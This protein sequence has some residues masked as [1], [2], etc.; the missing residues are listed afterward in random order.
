MNMFNMAQGPAV[1]IM[2]HWSQEGSDMD[3]EWLDATLESIK[4]QT[5]PNWKIL[6][7]DGSSPSKKAK[8]YLKK[9]EDEFGGKLEVIFME[10]S[11]GPGHARNVAIKKAYESGYPFL[12]FLDAD[13]IA[14]SQRVEIARKMF[15]EKPETGVVYS[16]F[17]V[18]DEYGNLVPQDKLS[19][20]IVEILESHEHNP[21]QGKEAW[22]KIATET[23]YT[24]L[25]STTSVRT[26]IAYKYPFPPEKVSE[27][28]YTWLV[29]SA[30]GTEFVYTPLTPTK[31][32]IP[33]HTEGSASRS[34]EGGKHG[35]YT[36]KCRV[37]TMGF[38]AAAKMA[39]ERGSITQEK[40]EELQ[41]KFLIKEA[42]TM[43]RE[44]ELDLAKGCY[45]QALEIHKEIAFD[46]IKEL[47]F[48]DREWVR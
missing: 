30:S 22:I 24:N 19:Q 21:P 38:Q 5:D 2:P 13:D 4:K 14:H 25:T 1:F 15:L 44:Q 31:Y 48:E 26:E 7:A 10:H 20:S 16:T 39:L 18:I 6:I 47:N 34:R 23:G 8:D 43:G 35:F 29:Y 33:Q 40:K 12:V 28:Y 46:I 11:D 37:D 36:T 41:I 42:E 32:R 45:H 27:D 3:R 17:E 9:L